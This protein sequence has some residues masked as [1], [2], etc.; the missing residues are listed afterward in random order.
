M[1][2][3]GRCPDLIASRD[4]CLAPEIGDYA[5]IG[6]CRTA[7]LVSREGS[8]DWLCLPYFSG[9]SVLAAIL[10]QERGGRFAIRPQGAFRSHRR[11]VGPTAVLET[12]FETATGTARLTD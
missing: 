10:D 6:D 7:A 2:Q 4:E 12:T 3:T 1:L 9:R 8:I 5:I 11:Y